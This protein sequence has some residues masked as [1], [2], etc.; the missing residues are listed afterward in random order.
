MIIWRLRS[1]L[2]RIRLLPV[3]QIVFHAVKHFHTDLLVGHL[4]TA[5]TQRDLGLIAIFEKA[6]QA[7]EFY[8]IVTFISTR[9]EFISLTWITFCF[10][11]CSLE[12]LLFS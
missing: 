5:E 3:H 6:N 4:T 1:S 8:L 7:A 12:D 9:A 11:F 10:F 2:G